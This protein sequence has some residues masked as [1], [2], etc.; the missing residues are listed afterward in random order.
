MRL[1]AAIMPEDKGD[2]QMTRIFISYSHSDRAIV[3]ELAKLLRGSSYDV[4]YD[5]SLHVGDEWWAKIIENIGN[6]DHFIYLISKISLNSHWCTKELEEAQKLNK[7]ILPVRVQT[8]IKP[9]PNL[10]HI[11]YVDYVDPLRLQSLSDIHA[12]II[13]ASTSQS[14]LSEQNLEARQYQA[15]AKLLDFL[16]PL[17]YTDFIRTFKQRATREDRINIEE[18]KSHILLYLLMRNKPENHFID[19]QLEQMF[20]NFD[21]YLGR[22]SDSLEYHY[23]TRFSDDENIDIKL[24]EPSDPVTFDRAR[25]VVRA[26]VEAAECHHFVVQEIKRKFP[27]FPFEVN[28]Q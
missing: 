24:L 20:G 16:W 4:W 23:S 11:Q 15:D 22:F 21:L 12:A 25:E 6:C 1:G 19:Q 26:L 3:D 18:Y 14:D 27:E 17:I 7:H 28:N 10:D 9:P 13:R 5:E 2:L 8:D